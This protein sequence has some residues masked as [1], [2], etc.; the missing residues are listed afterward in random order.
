MI[1][2]TDFLDAL[3]NFEYVAKQKDLPKDLKVGLKIH[4][5]NELNK[6]GSDICNI[7]F[8][9]EMEVIEGTNEALKNL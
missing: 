5:L 2:T 6:L 9:D 4:L 1:N 3:R 7:D 8:D